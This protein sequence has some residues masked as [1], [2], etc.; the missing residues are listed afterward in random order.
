ME[1]KDLLTGPESRK[2]MSEDQHKAAWRQFRALEKAAKTYLGPG[3]SM[4]NDGF[5]K[6][7]QLA[8]L[9][10]GINISCFKF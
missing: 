9:K 8:A 10:E 1:K 6:V 2:F 4:K 3:F 7:A 5:E